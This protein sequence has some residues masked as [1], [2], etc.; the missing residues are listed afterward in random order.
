ML[1]QDNNGHYRSGPWGTGKDYGTNK[2][3]AAMGYFADKYIKGN[4]SNKSKSSGGSLIGTLI[5]IAI[6]IF[7]IKWLME[8][9]PIV[10]F[11]LFSAIVIL[12]GIRISNKLKNGLWQKVNPLIE[13]E[14]FAEAKELLEK[15]ANNYKD[16]TACD[17][18]GN[19]Y[20]SG[21][22]VERNLEKSEHY[23]K[24][25]LKFGEKSY[26]P[27]QLAQILTPDFENISDESINYLVIAS[28]NLN[29]NASNDLAIIYIN[30]ENEKYSSDY[31]RLYKQIL[32]HAKNG[33]AVSQFTAGIANATGVI[34]EKNPE[35]AVEWYRKSAEQGYVQAMEGLSQCYKDGFGVNQDLTESE[36]WH[37]ISVEAE[38]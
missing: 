9:H 6:L 33:D 27:Y 37:Q 19:M 11:L 22:G 26:A 38:S 1:E 4:Q 23:Y 3:S 25:A 24:R 29:A 20:S 13:N 18:L 2:D 7:S 14:R 12:V 8:E 31:N 34:T 32:R 30:K 15:L 10:L 36:K 5:L 17:I 16:T 21:N 35:K 28:K